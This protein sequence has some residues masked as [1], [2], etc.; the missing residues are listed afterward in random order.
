MRRPSPSMISGARTIA[1]ALRAS[2][3]IAAALA[4]SD[5]VAQVYKCTGADGRTV[6][7]D[8]PCASGGK[9]MKLPDAATPGRATMPSVCEQLQDE[10]QRL[11]AEAERNAARGRKESADS[12]KRRRSLA[13]TYEARCAGIS[14]SVTPAK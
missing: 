10:R 7:A 2:I 3:L 4:A 11:A 8:A 13:K 1:R 6:Y 12:V 5:A 14:R 9:P